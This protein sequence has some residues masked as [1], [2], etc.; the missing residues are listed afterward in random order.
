MHNSNDA[1]SNDSNDNDNNNNDNNNDK[2]TATSNELEANQFR[3]IVTSLRHLLDFA[4]D[5]RELKKR[6]LASMISIVKS[7]L[8]LPQQNST[9]APN[10][11]HSNLPNANVDRDDNDD[12]RS[13]SRS[14]VQ[15]MIEVDERSVFER[16]Q[17][18][19]LSQLALI[20]TELHKQIASNPTQRRLFALATEP[21]L[22]DPILFPHLYE[23]LKRARVLIHRLKSAPTTKNKFSSYTSS[24][25]S[26]V[27]DLV[28]D[29]VLFPTASYNRTLRASARTEVSYCLYMRSIGK[30]AFGDTLA[31]LPRQRAENRLSSSRTKPSQETRTTDE[32]TYLSD[33]TTVG[34]TSHWHRD[35]TMASD[36]MAL[37]REQRR[38]LTASEF[39]HLRQVHLLKRAL[40]HKLDSLRNN[41]SQ[42]SSSSVE[43]DDEDEIG[44]DSL[45]HRQQFRAMLMNSG[46][47]G[48]GSTRRKRG[49]YPLEWPTDTT[50][51]I[52]LG[53]ID[54]LLGYIGAPAS[55]RV[56][57]IRS[58]SRAAPFLVTENDNVSHRFTSEL[59]ARICPTTD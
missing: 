27:S 19:N 59:L 21:N 25:S 13:R 2:E 39:E 14:Q 57:A 8:L 34:A 41:K 20:E 55:R 18:F 37:S 44:E 32:T 45:A 9:L 26:P 12:E 1:T 23:R 43:L 54:L 49:Q 46:G 10:L 38:H 51:K 52:P 47:Y 4:L 30:D 24:Y 15:P 50:P 16:I 22:D 58:G 7:K 36:T 48:T 42:S 28:Y 5:S 11:N 6:L 53:S 3:P 40:D 29:T 35:S 17:S 33:R 31:L 56:R